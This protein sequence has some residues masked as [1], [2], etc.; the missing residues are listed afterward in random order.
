MNYWLFKTEPESFS[1][2]DLAKAPKRGTCWDGVR[3]YQARNLLRDA[4]KTGDEVFIYYSSCA[5]PGIVGLARVVKAGYPDHT[6]FDRKHPHYDAGST[7]A[8]P[9]WYMVDVQLQRALKR[10]ITLDELNRHA[11]RE[12]ADMQLLKRGNRLSVMPVDAAHW[13]FILTL[14]RV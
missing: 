14:E 6:A 5:V 10:T 2:D 1:I 8:A 4:I 12:L 11:K 9:R 3:N 13:H 7:R